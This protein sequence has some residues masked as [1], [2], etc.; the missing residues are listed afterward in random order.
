MVLCP[1]SVRTGRSVLYITT[2]TAGI[3]PPPVDSVNTLSKQAAIRTS[4]LG[5]GHL[6]MA[7][8]QLDV[9]VLNVG[10]DPADR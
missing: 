5:N 9:L 1:I 7:S 3:L 6:V 10:P 4:W 8:D 2:A